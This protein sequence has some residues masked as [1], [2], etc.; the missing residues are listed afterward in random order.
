M[1]CLETIRSHP[2]KKFFLGK[3]VKIDTNRPAAVFIWWKSTEDCRN[4]ILVLKD[5]L[6]P[7]QVSNLLFIVPYQLSLFLP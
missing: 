6:K 2:G 1:F 7:L 4:S 5:C 3:V